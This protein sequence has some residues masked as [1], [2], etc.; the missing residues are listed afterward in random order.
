MILYL[1]Y[2]M[3]ADILFI[4]C[5]L[6]KACISPRIKDFDALY[7][8]LGYLCKYPTYS[9]CYYP[10]TANS[11]INKLL[12]A[13]NVPYSDIIVFSNASWQDCPDTGHS[14]ICHLTFYQGG[15]IATNS[16][17]PLSVAMYSAEA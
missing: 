10:I 9:I 15:L 2:S 8:L 14:T 7:W 3:R 13:N 6:A 12:D 1:A 17:V 11:P 5:K 4:I 16:G